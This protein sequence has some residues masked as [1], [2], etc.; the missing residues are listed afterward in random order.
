ML[1]VKPLVH[2]Y[3]HGRGLGHATRSVAVIRALRA[4]GY[5]VLAFAGPDGERLVRDAAVCRPVQSL[6]ARFGPRTPP[7]VARRVAEA[8]AALRAER[9]VAVVSDSD[10]PGLLAARLAGLP[11][12]AVGHGLMAAT[13]R[14]PPGASRLAWWREALKTRSSSL[15]A[16]HHVAVSFVPLE[17]L[18]RARTTVAAPALAP[19]LLADPPRPDPAAPLVAYFRDDNAHAVL[20][21]LAAHGHPVALFSRHHHPPRA[22]IATHPVERDA[23][24]A[25]LRR[26]PAVVASAGSQL[27]SECVY[28]GVPQFALHD[29]ADD[30]QRLNVELLR[31]AGLGNGCA[32]QDF[33]PGH[34]RQFLAGCTGPRRPPPRPHPDVAEAVV[35][36]VTQL[37]ASLSDAGE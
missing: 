3:V 30:E 13:C 17:P 2:Y 5:R 12:I 7:L 28:L 10:L 9:P 34:L 29:A 15:G 37:T 24:V 8:F 11:A 27:M 1:P 14:R 18:D 21:A 20:D 31:G 19:D 6:P 36:L 25:A 35:R 26:A 16:T 32:F 33:D 4:A 22:A 23:F